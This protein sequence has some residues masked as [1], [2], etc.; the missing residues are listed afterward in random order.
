MKA[1]I[2][3]IREV[4]QEKLTYIRTGDFFI[5][6]HED[7]IPRDVKFPAIGIKDG[8]ILR[9]EG[10]D[11]SMEYTM[12]VMLIAW[13]AVHKPEASIMG[14]GG[15]ESL[16][17]GVLDVADDIHDCLDEN[18]LDIDGLIEAFSPSEAGSETMGADNQFLQ[19]K[20]ITYRYVIQGDRP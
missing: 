5:A 3:A 19:K 8:Q 12:E 6:P 2:N 14:D 1:L 7:F 9:S 20:K 13:V 10:L 4:L 17:K 11:S 16:I 18:F 15:E